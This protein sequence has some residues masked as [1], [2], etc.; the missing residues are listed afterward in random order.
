V[1]RWIAALMAA[2]ARLAETH[3]LDLIDADS[4]HVTVDPVLGASRDILAAIDR[5][6]AGMRY[7]G[8][9][10]LD[11]RFVCVL[12]AWAEDVIRTDLARELPG[13]SSERLA[14]ADST[15]TNFFVTRGVTPVWSLDADPLPATQADGLLNGWPSLAIVRLWPAGGWGHVDGG[16]LDLGI[17]RD[18]ILSATNEAE[19]FSETF[20]SA[21]KL[22]G[23]SLRMQIGI[24]P[25]GTTSNGIDLDVCSTGS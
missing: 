16:T 12:P 25:N 5:A 9:F 15:I 7:R 17:V 4:T 19:M 3:L 20:E 2:Q 18:T 10:A 24:C 14:T 23:E 11:S 6:I 8:R 21:I 13:A 1:A 22:A